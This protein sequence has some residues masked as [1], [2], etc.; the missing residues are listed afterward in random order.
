MNTWSYDSI[1]EV[2]ATD[3]GQSMAFDDIGWYRQQ[4]LAAHGRVLELGCGSGRILLPL[5]AAGIDMVGLDRSLPMLRQLRADARAAG[6]APPP[7]VQGDLS[8]LP[9][10]GNFAL[11]LAPYS[12]VTYVTDDAVLVATFRQLHALTDD[13]GRLVVDVFVP[14]DV[15]PFDDFRRDYRRPH[16]AGVLEREKRI[17][18]LTDGCNRIERR[19]RLRD[20]DDAL[21]REWTTVEVIRPRTEARL[22]ELAAQAD[23]RL[24]GTS[25]DY[26]TRDGAASA[27]FVSLSLV[28][29]APAP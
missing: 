13:H 6:I 12:L 3:M 5:A 7:V 26:D 8:S 19:Y 1:A 25:Y 21:L 2:Y 15:A 14:R 27:Q 22:V 24:A 29:A 20:G 10:R 17:A 18:C 23:W 11:I 28:R 4:A 9:L 16:G